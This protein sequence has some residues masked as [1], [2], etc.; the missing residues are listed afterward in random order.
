MAGERP[1]I[2]LVEDDY[3][4]G[5]E[6]EATLRDAGMDVLGIATSADEAVALAG[7]GLPD[8]VVMDIRL[9]G[10]RD[11]VDAAI[12]I[13]RRHGIRSFFASAHADPEVKARAADAQPLGWI[14]KPYRADALVDGIRA[15]LGKRG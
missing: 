4:V 5:M 12:E 15:A 8:L 11:G 3:L 10:Q 13:F 14:A 6:A 7:E 1:R 2:L 9:A